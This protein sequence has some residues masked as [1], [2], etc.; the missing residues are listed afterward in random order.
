MITNIRSIILVFILFLFQNCKR[1]NVDFIKFQ[2]TTKYAELGKIKLNISFS[3]NSDTSFLWTSDVFSVGRGYPEKNKTIRID[4]SPE[5]VLKRISLPQ[6]IIENNQFQKRFFSDIVLFEGETI[7]TSSYFLMRSSYDTIVIK[8]DEKRSL[9]TDTI[10]I[11]RLK[12]NLTDSIIR[13]H[14]LFPSTQDQKLEGFKP[15]TITSNW[16][17]INQYKTDNGD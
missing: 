8:S 7:H 15:L 12:I 13:F 9:Q 14:Y 2:V 6:I 16:I 11:N 3:S 17:N 5:S 1:R 10:D 4:E